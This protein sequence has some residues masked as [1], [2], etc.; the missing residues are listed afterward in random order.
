M[1]NSLKQNITVHLWEIKPRSVM[2]IT[3]WTVVILFMDYRSWQRSIIQCFYQSASLHSEWTISKQVTHNSNIA[4][5]SCTLQGMGQVKKYI[6]LLYVCFADIHQ[7]LWLEIRPYSNNKLGKQDV[8]HKSCYIT[9]QNEI[10]KTIL[11]LRVTFRTYWHVYILLINHDLK[12]PERQSNWIPV[13]LN[14]SCSIQTECEINKVYMIHTTAAM[15]SLVIAWVFPMMWSKDVY[16]FYAPES[17]MLGISIK[18]A[19]IHFDDISFGTLHS[20]SCFHQA[21]CD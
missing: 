6:T 8:S 21:K 17:L 4:N 20:G 12:P 14:D 15:S 2:L 16:G 3:R 11:K 18:R 7:V 10:L 1:I 9:W 5:P 13:L 19:G